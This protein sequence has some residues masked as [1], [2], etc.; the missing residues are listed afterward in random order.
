MAAVEAN[1]EDASTTKSSQYSRV[2]Y[3]DV[4]Q[5][6]LWIKGIQFVASGSH[7]TDSELMCICIYMH[8]TWYRGHIKKTVPEVV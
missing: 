2:C 8:I 1:Q 3:W 5:V 7:Y 6:S 4:N